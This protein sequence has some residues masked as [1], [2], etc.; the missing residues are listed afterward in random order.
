M[1]ILF[2]S[3][4]VGKIKEIK[5]LL[6]KSFKVSSLDDMD[7]KVDI[8]ERGKT[9]EENAMIKSNFASRIFNKVSIADDSGIEIDYLKGAPG[10]YTARYAS[11]E[12]GTNADS[13]DTS[14]NNSRILREM[15]GVP[16]NKRTA[17][18]TTVISLTLNKGLCITFK[19]IVN[20]Y[21]TT[22]PIGDKGFGF[23]SIFVPEGYSK[24]FAEMSSKEKN[25]ISHRAIAVDRL[26]N[27]LKT[28]E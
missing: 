13:H 28:F 18:A 2:A 25:E 16:Y 1:E 21:I 6:P 23:D 7:R 22:T 27:Y 8:P 26:V 10:V 9:I 15:E 3:N 14:A 5:K 12:E 11:M 17:K 20:G 19:G 24:T 4:N